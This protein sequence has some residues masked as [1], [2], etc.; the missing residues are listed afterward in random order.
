MHIFAPITIPVNI[1]YVFLNVRGFVPYR[2]SESI[3][4]VSL[5]NFLLSYVKRNVVP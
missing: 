3:P 1:Q 4:S 5:V 2:L